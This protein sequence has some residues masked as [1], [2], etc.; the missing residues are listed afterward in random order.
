MVGPQSGRPKAGLKR[1]FTPF[2]STKLGFTGFPALIVDDKNKV[3]EE[4]VKIESKV[5]GKPMMALNQYVVRKELSHITKNWSNFSRTREGH[6][7]LKITG[8]ND[9]EKIKRT[10][11]LGVWDVQITKDEYKNSV[12]GVVFSRDLVYLT[13]E[14]ILIAF[15]GWCKENRKNLG[16]KEVYVPKRRTM[17]RDN[18][19]A[20]NVST[21]TRDKQGGG[22]TNGQNEDS[23]EAPKPFGL[24]IITFDA[25]SRPNTIG[26]GFDTLS[27]RKYVPNPMRCKKCLVLGH[28]H[29]RC[30]SIERC[31]KCGGIEVD[32]HTCKGE[33]CVNC[34]AEG[35]LPS[36]RDCQAYLVW[37]EY[38]EI[39]TDLGCSLF[40]AKKSFFGRYKTAENFIKTKDL[41]IAQVLKASLEKE[42]DKKPVEK[43]IQPKGV[44][45][46]KS[47]V[48]MAR[49]DMT[50]TLRSK[51]KQD[52]F[53]AKL[54]EI[55][56][57]IACQETFSSCLE[58]ETNVVEVEMLEEENS[59]VE[60][61]KNNVETTTVTNN[62]ESQ[63]NDELSDDKP[64]DRDEE[65]VNLIKK[66][67]EMREN[68]KLK[69]TQKKTNKK[70][71]KVKNVD[72]GNKTKDN[73]ASESTASSDSDAVII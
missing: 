18:K 15:D 44:E 32:G 62:R 40:E 48:K 28:T 5:P 57:E 67:E 17:T 72:N 64:E 26:Y 70:S 30:S 54:S 8:E 12:K 60:T 7:I 10:T 41:K 53:M 46:V 49:I 13:D 69:K 55:P 25:L 47:K 19:G 27:V 3:R 52:V 39:R 50:M 11:K 24:V 56:S 36:N 42:K 9:I 65:T 34:N 31:N 58:N 59:I 51:K 23:S 21:N 63:S 45:T 2:E 1:S 22:I 61:T 68:D 4:Y 66:L 20:N 35:H 71:K 37:K 73:S 33:F 29:K 16:V 38:E 14:E 6:I 43:A